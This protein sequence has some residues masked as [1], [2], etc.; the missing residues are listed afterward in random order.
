ME[1]VASTE[2]AEERVRLEPALVDLPARAVEKTSLRPLVIDGGVRAGRVHEHELGR[3]AP[4]LAEERDALSL[5]EV[6]VEVPAA[7]AVEAVVRE[8]QGEGVALDEGPRRDAARGDGEHAAARVETGDGAA[9]VLREEA[10]PTP[11]VERPCGR[12]RGES[13]GDGDELRAE[14]GPISVRVEADTLVPVVVLRCAPVVVG[15]GGRLAHAF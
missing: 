12:E 2:L 7:D 6:P 5:V 3:D 13:L 15:G 9:Q 10:G 1:H 11:D 8:G 4:R 14:A